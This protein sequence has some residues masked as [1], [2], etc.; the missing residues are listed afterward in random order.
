MK[1]QRVQ[2]CQR[3]LFCM[4]RLIVTLLESFAKNRITRQIFLA[5]IYFHYNLY[6]REFSA[7]VAFVVFIAE[8]PFGISYGLHVKYGHLT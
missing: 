5:F 7:T 8:T 2:R 1:I 3:C 4:F 6:I